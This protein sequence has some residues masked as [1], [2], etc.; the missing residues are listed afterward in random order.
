MDSDRIETL[1]L[2]LI[3]DMAE[4]KAKI[5]NIDEQKISNRIDVLE[6]QSKEQDRVIK[7]L[8]KRSEALEDFTR[9]KLLDNSK[10]M[11]GVFISGGIAIFT[12]VI[13]LLFNLL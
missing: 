3:Q 9:K 12:A 1:L 10:T 13:S 11:R 5:D 2:Q 4:V 6:A 7:S 8:E